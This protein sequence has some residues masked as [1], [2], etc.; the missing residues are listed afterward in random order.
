MIFHSAQQWQ[1]PL[2]INIQNTIIERIYEFNFLGLTINENLNWKRHVDK[3]ANKISKSMSILN[4]LK[5]FVPLNAKILIYTSLI[6]S[7][8]NFRIVA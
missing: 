8:L 4:K 7:Y 6:Y 1:N 5:Y 3:I 2:Q